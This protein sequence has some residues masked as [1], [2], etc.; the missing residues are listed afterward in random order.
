MFPINL[1][2]Y[3]PFPKQ[4][5]QAAFEIVMIYLL[6]MLCKKNIIFYEK[7]ERNKKCDGNLSIQF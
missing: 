1:K 7:K 4:G 2:E 3:Y 6:G 5:I